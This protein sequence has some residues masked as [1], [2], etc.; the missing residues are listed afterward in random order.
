MNT[1]KTKM[2]ENTNNGVGRINRSK[3]A[4]RDGYIHNGGLESQFQPEKQVVRNKVIRENDSAAKGLLWG[5]TLS[6]IAGLLGGS[7]FFLTHQ[8]QPSTTPSQVE[9]VPAPIK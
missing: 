9:T 2:P 8:N 6:A 4:Y 3:I 1:D 5:I 7:Y